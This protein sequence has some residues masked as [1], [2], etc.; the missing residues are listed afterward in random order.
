MKRA[1]RPCNTAGMVL[2][3]TIAGTA[4]AGM[5]YSFDGLTNNSV[6]NTQI[7]HSQLF[8]D[9]EPYSYSTESGVLFTFRNIGPA[10]SSIC[11]LY[12]DDGSLLALSHVFNGA[13]TTFS[14]F[15]KPKDLP[16]GE[17]A[18]PAFVTTA[19]FSA[20]ADPPVQPDGVNPG[21][22]VGIFFTLKYGQTYQNVISELASG[23]LRVGIHVQGFEGGGS[24]SFVDNPNPIPAP[25]SA[26]LGVV[27]LGILMFACR[28]L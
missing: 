17:H 2:L 15:A 12:F 21:E 18:T 1:T 8:F 3:L 22:E 16:G 11:D 25:A 14:Q 19:G 5:S 27:A 13:G 4:H 6:N 20:D 10:A 28:R 7:G 23:A 24:E 26:G 9:V